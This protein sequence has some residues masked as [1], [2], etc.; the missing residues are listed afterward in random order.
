M[1]TIE[2]LERIF[3]DHHEELI[4]SEHYKEGE[5]SLPSALNIICKEILKLKFSQE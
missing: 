1:K 3:S 5:F 4:K 2:E